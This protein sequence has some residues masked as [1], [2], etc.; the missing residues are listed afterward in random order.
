MAFDLYGT[1]IGNAL[2]T[3]GLK[4][5][6]G[7]NTTHAP[8]PSNES[9]PQAQS[10]IAGTTGM[11]PARQAQLDA[12]ARRAGYRNYEELALRQKQMQQGGTVPGRGNM[13]RTAGEAW[14]NA[15]AWHPAK[16]LSRIADMF[17]GI[18][19]GDQQ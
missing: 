17:R 4:D 1:P 9:L 18:N 12:E 15:M 8:P 5:F 2:N 13:P 14:D 6:L 3:V 19:E 16:I 10:R 7:S 11:D